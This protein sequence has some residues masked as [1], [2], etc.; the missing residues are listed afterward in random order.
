MKH[1]KKGICFFAVISIIFGTHFVRATEVGSND[2][3]EYRYSIPGIYNGG[4]YPGLIHFQNFSQDSSRASDR[5]GMTPLPDSSSQSS[6]DDNYWNNRSM[7][8]DYIR[9][10]FPILHATVKDHPFIYFDSGATAQMPQCVLDAMIEYYAGYK[11]NVGRGLYEYAEKATRMFEDARGKVAQF[12]G[13]QKQ[14]IVFTSGC[15]ASINLAAHIWAQHH[16]KAGDEI[17]ISEVEH[18]ANF[19]PW[20]QLA[21]KKGARLI[22]VPLN[23]SGYLDAQTV[24]SYISD[25]TKLVAITQQSNILGVVNDVASI[26]SVAHS[27]GAKVLVDAAQSIVHNKIDVKKLDCDFLVFSG[28]KL[29]GPTGVGV[30]FIKQSL[31]DQCQ[32]C[33]FGGGMVL[34]VT[35]EHIEIKGFP[36]CLEPGTQAIAQVIGLGAAIDFVQKNINFDQAQEYETMLA[37]K[38]IAALIQIPGITI[39]SPIPYAGQ[40]NSMVTFTTNQC[41]AYDVA[42]FLDQHGIAVR[43][44]Y[45]CVQPY[46]D[47]LGG[48]A[49]VRVSLTV[50]N[51]V[52]EVEYLIAC[53]QQFFQQ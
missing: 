12:I 52:Q 8:F 41:H 27:V 36:H 24:K 31:F 44:G 13:A 9:S 22:R 6:I 51:T 19:I 16:I 35:P 5:P 29:F 15:T 11:S 32:I 23:S 39:I 53:L 14:E 38:L 43:A 4:M 40:H 7:D 2:G 28:H 48:I 46:H 20:K 42:E 37:R 21:E 17:V 47:K 26:V 10:C 34:A 49:S 50:Y 3:G 1:T 33:N 45:H 30:L 25:K 18:N